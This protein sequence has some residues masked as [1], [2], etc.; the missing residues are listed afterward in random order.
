MTDSIEERISFTENP[1]IKAKQDKSAEEFLR[2]E[3]YRKAA[4]VCCSAAEFL[5]REGYEVGSSGGV[6]RKPWPRPV[7]IFFSHP[8]RGIPHLGIIVPR[9][10][11]RG[12]LGF[13]RRQRGLYVGELDMGDALFDKPWRLGVYGRDN[14]DRMKNL[15]E[16]L[17]QEYDVNLQIIL[18]RE[19]LRYESYLSDTA[20][21]S[22]RLDT[23]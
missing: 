22:E 21:Y 3:S 12:F 9:E 14:I 15:A 11:V 1:A 5:R 6:M 10:P 20:N 16:K 17:V 18:E 23:A 7:E 19:D 13:K 8:N 4:L 2:S